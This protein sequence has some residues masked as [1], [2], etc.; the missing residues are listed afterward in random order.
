MEPVITIGFPICDSASTQGNKDQ[1]RL[2]LEVA[3][4]FQFLSVRFFPFREVKRIAAEMAA[5]QPIRNVHPEYA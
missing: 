1:E 2:V 3:T 5:R 4:P